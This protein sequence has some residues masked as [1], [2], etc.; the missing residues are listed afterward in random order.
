[1]N[2]FDIFRIAYDDIQIIAERPE[3]IITSAAKTDTGFIGEI[4]L[5]GEYP[6]RESNTLFFHETGFET[7]EEAYLDLDQIMQTISIAFK[8]TKQSESLRK[9]DH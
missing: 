5:L 3:S 1:M 8:N 2:Y 9:N 7:A 4:V 6:D